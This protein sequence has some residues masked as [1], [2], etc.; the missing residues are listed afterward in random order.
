MK[1]GTRGWQKLVC[2]HI[3]YIVR[4]PFVV[5]FVRVSLHE[6]PTKLRTERYRV[7]S[8]ERKK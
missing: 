6:N 3:P 5:K 2:A 8:I 1:Q 4:M 7:H